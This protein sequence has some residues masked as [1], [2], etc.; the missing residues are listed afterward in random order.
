MKSA[1]P[2]QESVLKCNQV[3]KGQDWRRAGTLARMGRGTGA[4]I[5]LAAALMLV[6]A[7][8][9]ADAYKIGGKRWPGKPTAR[10]G[11]HNAA[12]GTSGRWTRP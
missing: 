3:V 10:I 1:R 5:G 12:P 7:A 2:Y 4:S 8:P 6:V 9:G 11:Y